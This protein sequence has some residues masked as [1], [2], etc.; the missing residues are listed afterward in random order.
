[1]GTMILIM[2]DECGDEVEVERFELQ[3]D[4]DEDEVEIW[5]DRKISKAEQRYPE[6]RG[7]YFEDRRRWNQMITMMI[8][9]EEGYFL[10]PDDEDDALE[11]DE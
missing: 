7:F 11:M 10:D 2:L 3:M 8:R 5:K 1:M 9:E 4:L 6:A